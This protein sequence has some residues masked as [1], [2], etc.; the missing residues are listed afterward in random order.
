MKTNFTSIPAHYRKLGP[1]EFIKKGDLY[2]HRLNWS[3]HIGVETKKNGLTV[4]TYPMYDWYRR[5]HVAVKKEEKKELYPSKS[6]LVQ[7]IYTSKDCRR[8]KVRLIAADE[9]YIVG[10]DLDDNFKYKKFLRKRAGL[11]EVVEFNVGVLK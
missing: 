4:E 1:E 9:K 5:R 3:N 8:R 11:I 10:L 7:F 2:K 6:P